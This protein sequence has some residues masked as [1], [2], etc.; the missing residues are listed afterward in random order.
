M[1]DNQPSALRVVAFVCTD[2]GQH[3]EGVLDDGEWTL[4]EEGEP[5]QLHTQPHRASVAA[6]N[7]MRRGFHENATGVRLPE[8]VMLCRRC[9]NPRGNPR[10]ARIRVDRLRGILRDVLDAMPDERIK[11]DVSSPPVSRLF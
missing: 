5:R 11:L 10:E 4:T 2:A 8:V 7:R 9:R 1:T 6:R 3:D